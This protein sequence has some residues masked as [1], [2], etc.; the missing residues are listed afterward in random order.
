MKI[1]AI[2]FSL[3]LAAAGIGSA[4]AQI[5]RPNAVANGAVLGGIAGAFIGGHNNDRWGQG[6]LIGAAAGA[7]VGAAV[8]QSRPVAHGR[9]VIGPVAW[10]PDAPVAY[11]AP[12]TV[13]VQSQACV[14]R[15]PRVV[16]VQAPPPRVVY[17]R[18]APRVVYVAAPSSCAPLV[19]FGPQ[20]RRSYGRNV[21]YV[22]PAYC[23]W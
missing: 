1:Q 18:S 3:S 6:A 21:I 11:A 14:D 10:V 22:E 20:M 5:F 7:L 9:P 13:Y 23:R 8:E 12:T 19:V 4:Q 15:N 16:Y 2:L 17:I